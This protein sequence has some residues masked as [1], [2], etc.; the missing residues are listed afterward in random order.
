MMIRELLSIMNK[1]LFTLALL[2]GLAC[3][4]PLAHA[5]K[6]DT[7]VLVNGNAVTG[8]I[9]ALEFGKLR[10]STD[11]MG[12]VQID[13]EDVIA[14]TSN[15]S[16]QV[17]LSDG[18]RYYGSLRGADD[19]YRISVALAARTGSVELATDD[20]VR[21]TPIETGDS[22]LEQL[23]G[24]VSF[25]LNTNKGS[26]VTT[27]NFD[28]DMRYRT[29]RYLVGL[30]ARSTITD[31]PSEETNAS[32]RISGN[33]QNFRPN[34]WFTD[35]FSSWERNDA[36]GIDSRVS[37]GGAL[38]RYIVQ[39]NLDQFS[40]LAG[41]QGTRESRFGETDSK[42]NAEGR[43]QVRYLHRN[44]EPDTSLTFT[45][46]VYPL[47]KDLEQFR[48]QANLSF[49]REFIDDLYLDLSIYHTYESESS[50][51][52]ELTDYGVTTSLGYSF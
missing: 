20:I 37:L 3:S 23:E 2:V 24:S 33:Y 48:S 42:D 34:R 19:R 25:G 17:E 15:Q 22:F 49:R 32:H 26:E 41:V 44:L 14:V 10:Y 27:L 46:D 18:R 7:V 47:L 51:G 50:E 31:Q 13:W 40:L 9:K 28:T 16:L 38:G 1:P 45:A 12:T 36:T 30:T 11:S 8:E 35:W 5:Q 6:T 29:L 21:I 43:I 4:M 39:T 52:A